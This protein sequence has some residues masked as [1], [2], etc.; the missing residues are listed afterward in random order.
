MSTSASSRSGTSTAATCRTR[1][2][3]STGKTVEPVYGKCRSLTFLGKRAGERAHRLAARR[4]HHRGHPRRPTRAD[5][6]RRASRG[7]PAR[8]RNRY[9][10]AAQLRPRLPP[11]DI[12]D[13]RGAG[14]NGRRI[15]AVPATAVA[16]SERLGVHRPQPLRPGQRRASVSLRQGQPSRR[17]T[18]GSSST[19]TPRTGRA[20]SAMA[21]GWWSTARRSIC[22]LMLN[23]VE[24]I[25]SQIDH[26]IVH[27]DRPPRRLR[28]RSTGGSRSSS[29][30]SPRTICRGG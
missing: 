20:S 4:R 18:P 19:A 13:L 6:T 28:R 8:V 9:P 15:S 22:S 10:S 2:S 26:Y 11:A 24:L 25:S 1:S 27:P 23:C 5:L 14:L 16:V 12:V 7:R 17:S 30:A 3:A 21:S 29:T